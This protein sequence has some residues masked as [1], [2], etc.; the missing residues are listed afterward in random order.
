MRLLVRGKKERELFR[1]FLK[2][3]TS[4]RGCA[5]LAKMDGMIKYWICWV[6]DK[7]IRL[8][9]AGFF[10]WTGIKKLEDLS[11]FTESVGNF[12]FYW[13][14][15]WAGETRN[16]FAEPIDAIIAYTVPWLEIVA[17]LALLL[18]WMRAAGGVTL[19]VLLASF[20][21]ALVY[22][23]NLGIENLQCGC[24]GVSEE[25]TNYTL[26]IASNFGL[27]ALVG[28][29]FGL[30]WAQ[31]RLVSKKEDSRLTP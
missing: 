20:N 19:V 27:M 23:W 29:V 5:I 17:A 15:E 26:K 6:I 31:R 9:L 18:P 14:V 7:S 1:G 25:S 8:F 13:E 12:Q 22:A 3:W 16:F 10:V 21:G 28:M 4:G 11:A 24:H 30:I 2:P